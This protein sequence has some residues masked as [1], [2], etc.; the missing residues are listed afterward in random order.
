MSVIILD[1]VMAGLAGRCDTGG[2]GATAQCKRAKGMAG[3]TMV[4]ESGPHSEV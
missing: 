2:E 4:C 1:R 3:R